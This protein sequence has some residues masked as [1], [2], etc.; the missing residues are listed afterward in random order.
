MKKNISVVITLVIFVLLMP[1]CIKKSSS[2]KDYPIQPVPFT[3]VKLTDNFWAPRI[4]KN[5]SVTIP[6]AFGYCESTGRV[7]NFE[8]AAGLDTGKFQTIY[9]FDDSD[10]YKIIE[11]ASYSLQ[12]FP[13]PKL[14][15]YLDT[16]IR[17]SAWHRSL[18]VIFIPTGQL[19]RNMEE[20]DLHEWAGK[21][22]WEMDS[23]L[24]H[25][26][27]NLGHL[28]EAAVAHYQATGKRTLL[29]IALKSADLVNKDFG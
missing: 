9:P 7:K 27:Y 1:G 13:D 28:Y 10:V 3:S 16:L 18:T 14:E 2:G 12:T 26:L 23:V 4:K 15:A 8:I 21:N 24:S 29:N 11:G 25:E 17:K 20:K 5:A 6:I 19:L 22:R